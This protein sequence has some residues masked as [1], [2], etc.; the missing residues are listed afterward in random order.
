MT[1]KKYIDRPPRIEPELPSGVREIPNPPD[2]EINPGA[3]L[4]QAALPMIMIFG[5]ILVSMFGQS[6]SMLMMIPMALSVV[7]SVRPGSLYQS[8]G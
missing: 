4:A 1:D 6:S 7:A 5:Y 8:P 2:V 3:I